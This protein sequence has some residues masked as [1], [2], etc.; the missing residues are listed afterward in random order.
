LNSFEDR[1][2]ACEQENTRLRKRIARQNIVW[3][4][5]LLLLAG[6]AAVAGTTI[7][8]AI[9]DSIRAKEIVVVDAK[10]VIRARMS[11]DMPDA[12]YPDGR[13]SKR[14]SKAGGFMIYDE[15]G[16]ERGGYVTMDNGSNAMLTLDSKTRQSALFVAGPEPSQAS[17]LR[18]WTTG[19]A[20]EMRADSS[21]SRL[22]VSDKSGV[23]MQ[24]PAVSLSPAKCADY[25]E[26]EKKYPGERACQG[27]FTEAAC[28]VCLQGD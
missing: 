8:N 5:G 1:L 25:K 10:G 28:N 13:V 18:L 3:L 22:S 9:F 17:A 26:I 16:T 27:R 15:E 23:T 4:S 21:G 20:I 14:G 7:K 24:Q 11:G 2:L 19:S 6:G 12:V